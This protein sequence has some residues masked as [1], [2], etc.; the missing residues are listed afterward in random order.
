MSDKPV[1][2]LPMLP[3]RGLTI[4]PY[5]VLHF[6]VGRTRSIAALEEAMVNNQEIFLVTQQDIKV[7]EPEKEDI[8]EVGTI[9]KIK[10]LLKLPGETIRVLVEGLERGRILEYTKE[11]PYFEVNLSTPRQYDEAELELQIEAISRNVLSSFEEYVK[12]SNKIS[13][14]TLLTVHNLEDPGSLADIIAANVLVRIEDKQK[15]LEAF[16]PVERLETLYDVLIREIEILEIE[17]KI[18]RRVKKQVDKVQREYYL[19]EQLKAIQKELGE[20]E[21]VAGEIE[22]YEEKI[23]KANLPEEANEKAVRELNR[24]SKMGAGSA[25]G[26]VIRT[27]LDWILDLPWNME[28]EDSLDLKKAARILDEDHYG[29]EKVKERVIEYL[30]VRQ[31]TKNMKGPILCFVGPPGVGKTSIAK[32][33]ARSL[34]RRFVRMSVGGV[35]DEAEIRGHRRTYVGAIPGRII[36]SIKQAGS[37]NPVFLLDEIDKM[38]NDFRGDPASAMLEVLDAEQN[39]AFRDHYLELAFDLSKVMFLTTANTLD[40]IPRPLLDRMEVIQISGY[41]EEEKRNIASR[42]LIPKQMKE[43]GIPEKGLVL[44]D[45]T[46]GDIINYYTREAG[47]RNLERQIAAICRK[48][49]RRILESG[50]SGVRVTGSNLKKYLG[51]PRFHYD[52]VKDNNETG[53]VT[54]LAWTSVGGDTLSIEVTPMPGTGKLVLTGQ[55]GDVMKES[56]RAGFSYIRSRAKEFGL[57]DDFHEKL[58]IHIHIPEGAIPKDG[59]SAGITMTTAVISALTGIPAR[60]D[61]AMTGEITLRGRILP[62]GGLKEKI[63]AAHRAG[64]R[65]VLIPNE[66]SR[67]LDEIGEIVKKKVNIVLVET[68][69]DVLAHSLVRMPKPVSGGQN[70]GD[71]KG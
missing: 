2:R 67:D 70:H 69:D 3:L 9:S 32:S 45:A 55:L 1:K 64:I 4:F 16:H 65:K 18:N 71:K 62:I 39:F 23:E 47:V 7:D 53:I 43:H 26:S 31:L 5:M 41:T 12:L 63:L 46:I 8:F 44:S 51:A 42:Y 11:E 50:K 34:N 21:G 25:E 14:E 61:V 30:A 40:T 48:A 22:A 17:N 66:N 52:K 6:D 36:A 33:I 57:N 24:L 29:L 56:A 19:R 59:P 38:S 68:M 28:T 10:Q 49:A 60:G 20:S 15:V 13:P 37:K 27:Y 54:G 58:D 35:R